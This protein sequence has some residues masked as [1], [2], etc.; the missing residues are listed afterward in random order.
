MKTSIIKVGNSRGI[1]LPKS[2]IEEAN[3]GDDVELKLGKN[4]ITISQIKPEV[5]D[6]A[7][8]SEKALF[9]WLSPVEDEAWQYLQ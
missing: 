2:F 7:L 6:E 5:N 3:L 9:D 8:L 1:R 4:K